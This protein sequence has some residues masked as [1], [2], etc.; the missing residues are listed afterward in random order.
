[1]RTI[2]IVEDDE[3]QEKNSVKTVKKSANPK[4]ADGTPVVPETPEET[5]ESEIPAVQETSKEK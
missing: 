1:M 2:G 3:K 4:K 5:K